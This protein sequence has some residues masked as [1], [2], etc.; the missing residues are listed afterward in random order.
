MRICSAGCARPAPPTSPGVAP[1]V[2]MNEM[3]TTQDAPTD[4][5]TLTGWLRML[6]QAG[7]SD[8]HVKAGSPPR[9]RVRGRL[10]SI[11]AQPITAQDA[12]RLTLSIV[13]KA[14]RALFDER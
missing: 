13:P 9:I 3:T 8:L 12:E 4:D 1:E 10:E 14:R 5:S 2:V 7:G 6:M 11:G